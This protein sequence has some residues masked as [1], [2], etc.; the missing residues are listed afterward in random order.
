MYIKL[1]TRI[2]HNKKSELYKDSRYILLRSKYGIGA[3]A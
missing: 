3:S 2:E 1:A